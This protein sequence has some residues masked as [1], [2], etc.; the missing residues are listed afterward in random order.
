MM[1]KLFK[2]LNLGS[3]SFSGFLAGFKKGP[4]GIIKNIFIILA[5]IYIFAV[6]I[7]MY[8]AYMLGTYRYLAAE[9]KED[10]MPFV[11]LMVAVAVIMFFGFTSVS[12]S[13][14]TGKGEEFLMSLPLTPAQLFEGKFAVSFVTDAIMG[15]GM[16]AISSIV[17]GYNE[18]LLTNPLFYLGFLVTAIAF[19]VTSVYVIYLLFIL[20]LFFIPALRKKKI[21]TAVATVLLIAFCICYGM[22]N[23]FASMMFSETDFVN[24]KMAASI[25]TLYEFSNKVPVFVYISGALKGRFIP[26]LI[27]AALASLVLFVLV[28][29][30]GK[31]YVSSLNG[32]SD[33]KTKKITSLKAEQVINKDVKSL[34]I[35][36]AVFKRDVLNVL[37][38]PAFFAN[39]PL[40]VFLF[41]VILVISFSVGFIMSGE[42]IPELIN[43]LQMKMLEVSSE[44]M[45][46]L[47]YYVTLA[48][49]A[50]TVFSGT[51]A[52]IATTSF[53]R[54][55]KSLN[56]L[57][58]MP[59]S[60]SIIVKAKFW[61]AMMYIGIA[62][63]VSI[64]IL[65]ILNSLFGFSIAVNEFIKICIL[66]TITAVTVSLSLI[67]IDMFIDTA[68][69]KL[70]WE[71]PMA[72]SKQNF[73]VLW[74]MLLTM[75]TCGIII[76]LIV[77]VLPK[78]MIS[79]V[80]LSLIFTLISS[81]LGAG[82]FKYA[83]KKI[84]R[85]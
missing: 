75:V 55:G 53:S 25:N 71:N 37:R 24:S 48:A 43:A 22:M 19:S 27:L 8:S 11:A 4:K 38:E 73:N 20:I 35:F 81:P 44:K 18:G 46:T 16:F 77:L 72:A 78:K 50:F 5:A 34:S 69:P 57:K 76:V 26:I 80:I 28:P 9:G 60:N 70:V 23:S 63:L 84:S 40:F 14:Y 3:F 41:P 59:I 1:Y 30:S 17:Y 62:D 56:D 51:F 39:G 2:I 42:S 58:A 15:I 31:M 54:E 7:G 83:E 21:L 66:M 10:F 36:H 52:N 13:Y 45:E 85:M 79:F 67:F 6:M 47:K 33:V 12:S 65:A 68:N 29:L 49:A 32:F 74:S 64:I 82:Y 61:H